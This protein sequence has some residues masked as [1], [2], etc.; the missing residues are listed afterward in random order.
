M[1]PGSESLQHP[2][3]AGSDSR[4]SASLRKYC[5]ML[6]V[7]V[8]AG[9]AVWRPLPGAG[10]A[11]SAGERLAHVRVSLRDGTELELDDA[12]VTPDSIVGYGGETRTRFAVARR[13]VVGVEGRETD[14]ARTFA[15]GVLV[16][17]AASFLLVATYAALLAASG[18]D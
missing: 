10:F 11:R 9:C 7:A 5:A 15:V 2:N 14:G 16:P 3:G 17:I 18:A 6:T 8:V 13:E 12:S 4:G 1:S